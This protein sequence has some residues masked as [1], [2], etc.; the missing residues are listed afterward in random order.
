MPPSLSP[1]RLLVLVEAV[2]RKG[3]LARTLHQVAFRAKNRAAPA[4][5]TG[6]A[7]S[8]KPRHGGTF[9][10]F[11]VRPGPCDRPRH[12]RPHRGAQPGPRRRV[13][14][15]AF[16]RRKEGTPR[17]KTSSRPNTSLVLLLGAVAILGWSAPTLSADASAPAPAAQPL[18]EL[19]YTPSLD[20]T[21]MDRCVDPCTDLYLYSCGGWMKSHPLPAD[22]SRWGVYG[23]LYVDNQQYLWGILEA[24][25]KPDPARTPNQQKI[26]DYFS[27][28]MDES[29]IAKAGPSPLRPDLEAIDALASIKGL[30]ALLGKL[31]LRA[32]TDGYLFGFFAEQ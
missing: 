7:L 14:S 32:Q 1:E 25:S 20:V 19:P 23:K 24:A 4:T 12:G 31:H 29:A 2:E 10:A 22:Q 18:T 28:C 17:M 3:L 16:S 27:S 21:A 9:H 30:P 11:L 8:T 26:G 6:I 13:Y 15:S 5:D